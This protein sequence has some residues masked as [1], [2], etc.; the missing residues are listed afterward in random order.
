MIRKLRID[1]GI[2]HYP[3]KLWI[4]LCMDSFGRGFVREMQG[5]GER[6]RKKHHSDKA[7]QNQSVVR[8]TLQKH[9]GVGLA[10]SR[11]CNAMTAVHNRNLRLIP[12]KALKSHGEPVS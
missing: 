6:W 9:A 3:H 4:S 10:R 5:F 12:G 2:Q 8:E 7:Q 1:K 11:Y